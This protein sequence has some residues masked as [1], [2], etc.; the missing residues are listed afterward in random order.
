[1]DKNMAILDTSQ[2]QAGM[3]VE[4]QRFGMGKVL[5][6]EGTPPDLKATIFFNGLGNK[7]L[8]LKFAKLKILG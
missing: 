1:M 4:H 5:L 2:I 8:L 6:V 3:E 7:Q